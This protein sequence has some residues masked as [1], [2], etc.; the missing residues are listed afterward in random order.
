[1]LLKEGWTRQALGVL[2][3]F[4]VT[5]PAVRAA[6]GEDLD[7]YKWRVTALWWFSNPTG[8]FTGKNNSGTFDLH[9]DFGFGSYSTFSGNI[10]W[11]FKRKHHLIF[12]VS[13][14][15]SSRTTTLQRTIEFQGVVYD[16]DT[17]VSADIKSFAFAPG[18]QYDII[19]RDHVSVSFA[20][21]VNLLN[22]SADLSGT[23]TVNGQSETRKASGSLFAP[24]PTLGTRIRWYPAHSSRLAVE[25]SFQGMSFFGYGNFMSA[26]GTANIAMSRVWRL[27]LGYQMGTRLRIDTGTNEIGIRLTQKGPVAGV[28]ASW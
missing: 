20:T 24:L 17:K 22:T 19:R 4:L 10:D 27:N 7:V 25:G 11:R 15:V 14:V 26:R 6:Q 18:Y 3:V 28:E 5:T 21:Q 13:P 23:V 8:S 16:V 12:G 9:R 1:M 2:I